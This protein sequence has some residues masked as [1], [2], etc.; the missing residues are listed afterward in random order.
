MSEKPLL[1]VRLM[2]YNHEAYIVQAIEGGLIQKCNFHFEIVIG[3]DF[4]TDNTLDIC[5]SYEK[6]HPEK[7]R[8]LSRPVGGDY[9]NRRIN[10]THLINFVDIIENSRGKYIALLDGDDFWTDPLKLQK[11]LDFLEKNQ[12]CSFCFHR[13]NELHDGDLTEDN[14][15]KKN[16]QN[17]Y[18]EDI[19]NKNYAH[20][21]SI[22]FR[23]SYLYPIPDLLKTAMPGDHTLQCLLL[24]NGGY[25]FYMK[26][27]MAVYRKHEGGI[28]SSDS[29]RSHLV[30][31]AI[32][33]L[34]LYDFLGIYDKGLIKP[35]FY[36]LAD[37]IVRD[38]YTGISFF[39]YRRLLCKYFGVKGV[40]F[41]GYISFPKVY[42]K[43]RSFIKKKTV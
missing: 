18:L 6:K 42:N 11:Q 38:G 4:S 7:I 36:M 5:K 26:E 43:M 32:S 15:N 22:V 35:Q 30:V 39:A 16:I 31:R 25:A 20:T 9:Y 1:T 40:A 29:G 13:V 2:S 24:R 28:W 3:D 23:K 10:G 33:K 8:V 34:K 12:K 17:F 41:L 19:L 27:N 14:L 21:S 37:G